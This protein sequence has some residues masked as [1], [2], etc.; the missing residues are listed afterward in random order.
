METIQ[1]Q[2]SKILWTKKISL[3]K[4]LTLKK[5]I[6]IPI[7]VN[8]SQYDKNLSIKIKEYLDK[9]YKTRFIDRNIIALP[10]R[11]QSCSIPNQYYKQK[12]DKTKELFKTGE[13]YSKLRKIAEARTRKE[14]PKLH[15]YEKEKKKNEIYQEE[16]EKAL[17]LISKTS[18]PSYMCPINKNLIEKS[19]SELKEILIENKNDKFYFLVSKAKNN[20][21]DEEEKEILRPYL[22]ELKEEYP[23]IIFFITE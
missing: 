17:D 5:N 3:Q 11:P 20:L 16:M 6:I 8:L 12:I 15:K 4:L 10:V 2:T 13:I 14:F 21:F 1:A 22:L 7:P 9:S 23:N 18:F 19:I